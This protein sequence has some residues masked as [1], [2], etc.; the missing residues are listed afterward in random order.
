MNKDYLG[1]NCEK[2]KN[3]KLFL[4]DMDGT[5]YC[6]NRLFD[7][8]I[9]LLG[10]IKQENGHYV[11][12]TNNASKSVKDYVE[13]IQNMGIGV[14][15]NN[16]LTS[17]Q[18]TI[19]HLYKNH[20]KSRIYVQGTKSFINELIDAGLDVT[21]EYDENVDVILVGFDTEITAE[22][23]RTTSKMLTVNKNAL[24]YA[25]NPDWVCPVDFGYIPDCGS[26]CFGYEKATGRIPTFI[27]KPQPDMINIAMDKFG[28]SKEQTLV[29]GDRLYTDIASGYNAGVDTVLVLSGE[30]TMKDYQESDIKP[31]FVLNSVKDILEIIKQE[32][33][34]N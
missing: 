9:E 15:E 19:I 10:I 13:N 2:L 34:A 16:F 33:T 27:G 12:I 26:M 30:A 24:Y 4:F 21:E 7:G 17:V 31:T 28:F 22:K 6:E 29:I 32:K 20:K 14:D 3:K 18:A 1:K 11:F 25:T 8:V 23:M 5:I